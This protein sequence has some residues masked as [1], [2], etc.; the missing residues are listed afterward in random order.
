MSHMS[1]AEMVQSASLRSRMT[2][3]A[4][5][6]DLPIAPD[7]W[8]NSHLWSLAASEGWAEAWDFAR[9]NATLD[10]NPDTGARPGVINDDMITSAIQA[11]V[12]AEANA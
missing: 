2:A 3:A 9:A 11:L 10:H 12:A 8:V 5:A 7:M 1:T 4:A 6:E